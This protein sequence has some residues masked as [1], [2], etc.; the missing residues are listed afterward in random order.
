[1]PVPGRVPARLADAPVAAVDRGAPG[2]CG[3]EGRLAELRPL[4][5]R[6][7]GPA[8]AARPPRLDRGWPGRDRTT[9]PAA[10][11]VRPTGA[12]ARPAA[13]GVG[14]VAADVRSVGGGGEET[15]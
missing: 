10:A 5:A 11:G 4:S 6:R 8:G 1:E 13:P 2:P 14:R 9:R 7:P 12:V 15:G 3:Q